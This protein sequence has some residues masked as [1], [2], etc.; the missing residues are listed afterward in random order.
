M[1][2][3]SAQTRI[4]LSVN[5]ADFRAGID[6]LCRLCRAELAADPFSGS[7]RFWPGR[8]GSDERSAPMAL[9]AHELQVLL[10]GGNPAAARTAPL[11]RP[12]V[13]T[14]PATPA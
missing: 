10:M 2:Q 3:L 13:V 11:W 5:P 4:L 8:I 1:M 7:F 6:G 12:I 14:G 9:L